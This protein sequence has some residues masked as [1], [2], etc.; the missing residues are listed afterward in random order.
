MIV[1]EIP[2]RTM[3]LVQMGSTLTH[4]I[5]KKGSLGTIVKFTTNK[6]ISGC[7]LQFVKQ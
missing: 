5:A 1:I 4:V 3:A 2:V 7:V 6:K